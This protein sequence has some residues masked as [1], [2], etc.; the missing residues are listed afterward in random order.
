M[1]K[2]HRVSEQLKIEKDLFPKCIQAPVKY[3]NKKKSLNISEKNKENR[4]SCLPGEQI[5]PHKNTKMENSKYVQQW[6]DQNDKSI[7]ENRYR[8]PFSDLK[9]N[10]QSLHRKQTTPIKKRVDR[11]LE[12][13]QENCENV[14]KRETNRKRTHFKSTRSIVESQSLLDHYLKPVEKKMPLE[15]T[16]KKF[17]L[18]TDTKTSNVLVQSVLN[19]DD[20]D[21]SGIVIDD[22]PIV[23]DDSQ[24]QIIDKD[25]V[26]WL[27]VLRANENET[28]HSTPSERLECSLIEKYSKDEEKTL[29]KSI[30]YEIENDKSG[31]NKVPFFK[32]GFLLETCKSCIRGDKNQLNINKSSSKCKDVSITI[33]SKS[34]T[35]IITMSNSS[36]SH[37]K[38]LTQSVP[39]QTDIQGVEQIKEDLVESLG[40]I[41]QKRSND[42]VGDNKN[43]QIKTNVQNSQDLFTA[44]AKEFPENIFDKA[45]AKESKR[46]LQKENNDTKEAKNIVIADSDSDD[47]V[48]LSSTMQVTADVHRSSDQ[49]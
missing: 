49:L 6:L 47:D 1:F 39:I 37:S 10:N 4:H 20:K 42:L 31:F 25:K 8:K 18:E 21:E 23:I 24:S 30:R 2:R 9:V 46:V 28:F 44:E 41:E 14:T 5:S 48:N 15:Y 3:F 40:P 13:V 26:A 34:F 38:G 22:E 32:K 19:N 43:N 29:P 16:P 17:K 12:N 27:A 33:E 7:K 11:I 45:L 35:T 36:Q